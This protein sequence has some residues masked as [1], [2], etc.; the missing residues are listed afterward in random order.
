MTAARPGR[1]ATSA[2][3]SPTPAERG[4]RDLKQIINLR[5][6]YHQLEQ[7]NRAHVILCWRALPLIRIAETTAGGIWP[8]IRRDPDRL[9]L[10]TVTG[11]TATFQAKPWWKPTDSG[12][13]GEWG[14]RKRR[15]GR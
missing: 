14:G 1:P 9:N 3:P 2:L 7:R 6:V 13:F 12:L 15:D 5:P 10:G 11:P 8:H 4:W